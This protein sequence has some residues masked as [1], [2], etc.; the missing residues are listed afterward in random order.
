MADELNGNMLRQRASKKVRGEFCMRLTMF[1]A[2]DR[3]FNLY[4]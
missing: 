2:E 1:I 4:E 3:L